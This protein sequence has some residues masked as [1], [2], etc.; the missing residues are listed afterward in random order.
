MR[1]KYEVKVTSKEQLTLPKPLREK[2][3]I[4]KW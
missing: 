3:G 1:E 2:F 4:S